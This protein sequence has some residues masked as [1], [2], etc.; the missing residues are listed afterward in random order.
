M[1]DGLNTFVCEPQFSFVMT[2]ALQFEQ[3]YGLA[4]SDSKD[5]GTDGM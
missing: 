1:T 5:Q 4:E 3:Q 2:R